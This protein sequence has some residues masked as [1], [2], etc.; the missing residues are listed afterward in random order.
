MS[1]SLAS[2]LAALEELDKAALQELWRRLFRSAPPSIRRDLLIRAIGHR[3]QELEMG[4]LSKAAV[5]KL[6][7]L[8]EASG[9]AGDRADDPQH[10]PA[11]RGGAART[12][13]ATALPGTRLIREWHGRTHVVTVGEDGFDYAGKRYGSLSEIAREITGTRW[14]GPRFFGLGATGGT[15]RTQSAKSGAPSVSAPIPSAAVEQKAK[16]HG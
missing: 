11:R 13:R 4:G 15:A 5:R 7:S 1:T 9:P 14:S 2:R 3:M 12:T 10:G 6:R 8:A 16:R